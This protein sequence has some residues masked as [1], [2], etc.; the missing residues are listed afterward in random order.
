MKRYY[1]L[2]LG[3]LAFGFLSACRGQ[4]DIGDGGFLSDEPCRAPCFFGIT[5]DVTTKEQAIEIFQ[6]K[7]GVGNCDEWPDLKD[8]HDIICEPVLVIFNDSGQIDNI[9]FSPAKSISIEEVIAKHGQPDAYMVFGSSRENMGRTTSVIM[10]LYFDNIN[11]EIVLSEQDGEN[12]FIV[13]SNII[14][15][16]N[17][18]GNDEWAYWREDAQ[19]WRGYGEYKGPYWAGP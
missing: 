12:Y 10:R 8:G 1:F 14:E 18:S 2:I 3:Y 17:Y 15:E 7:F 5:P 6:K 4:L 9:Y 11:T 16:I 13:S 19:P